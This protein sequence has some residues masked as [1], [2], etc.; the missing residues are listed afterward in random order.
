MKKCDIVM[1]GGIT[2]GIVYP[3]VVC[4]LAEQYEFQSIGGTSAGGIAAA[5]TAA[6]ELARREK[7]D[8]FRE[9]VDVPQWLGADSKEAGGSNLFNLFQPQP[10]MR[11]LFRVATAFLRP[12]WGPTLRAIV[13]ILWLE[14]LIGI[15]PAVALVAFA[16]QGWEWQSAIVVALG[17]LAAVAGTLVAMLTGVLLRARLLP[18]HHYGFCKGYTH[19]KSGQPISLVEW[20]N[21]KL[22]SFAAMPAGQPLTFGRLQQRDIKLKMVTTCLTFGRPFTLPFLANEFYFCPTEMRDYFPD[23]VVQWMEDHPPK[24]DLT[25]H[26]FLHDDKLDLQ[27]LKPMPDHDDLPVIVSVRLSLSFPVLFCAVPL[28]A[29]DFT[30]RRRDAGDPPPM[31]RQPGDAIGHD[32]LRTPERVWFAD[33]GITSNFPFHLFDSPIPRW[34]TFG[35]DLEDLR[36]DYVDDKSRTWMPTSNLGGM[37][38]TWTRLGTSRSLGST[39]SALFSMVDA[40]RNWMDNLQATAPGYRDRIV[41]VYLD[42]KEG[43]LNL[44]MPKEIVSALSQYGERAAEHLIEHFISGTEKGKPTV[45]TWDNHRWIRYRST[46]ALLEEFLGKYSNA[47]ENRETGDPGLIPLITRGPDD[48]PKTGYRLSPQ[49]VANALDVTQQ[50]TRLGDDMRGKDLQQ[51]APKP[52]PALRVRPTF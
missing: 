13:R 1:K 33:G 35:L 4:K 31:P 30:R 20:L 14:F 41:H 28:Y 36:A 23:E 24:R 2:S 12:G 18:S 52:T 50:L 21:G 37:A 26:Q 27:G 8:V 9:L 11:V 49:Q 29:V 6:A 34:P 25:E 43:G 38:H 10:S 17:L 45:M 19:R 47:M 5:L 16:W 15:A 32:E 44:N 7:R 22:N 46:V 42:P 40:A 51:G 3:G 48:P 39:V